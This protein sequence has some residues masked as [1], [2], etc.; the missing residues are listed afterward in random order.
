MN[1]NTHIDGLTPPSGTTFFD[2]EDIMLFHNQ[3]ITGGEMTWWITVY[4]YC[5]G[6]IPTDPDFAKK[7]GAIIL[8]IVHH[9]YFRTKDNNWGSQAFSVE[10]DSPAVR[11]LRIY[12]AAFSGV[13]NPGII[14]PT[15]VAGVYGINF[16]MSLR[17]F[18]NRGHETFV[19]PAQYKE[20]F[21]RSPKT[22]TN[23]YQNHDS[24]V[25]SVIKEQGASPPSSRH[26]IRAVSVLKCYDPSQKVTFNFKH[27]ASHNK[28]K[29]D[30]L[31]REVKLDLSEFQ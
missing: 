19:F 17:L 1:L 14:D 20:T 28:V 29:H 16:E 6:A 23:G 24:H 21:V 4:K 30:E 11:H 22:A 3:S 2:C 7:R 8:V 5:T 26:P 15:N 18:K 12:P 10:H 13:P 27:Y 9:G 31:V 25:F